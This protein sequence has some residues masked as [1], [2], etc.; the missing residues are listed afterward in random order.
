MKEIKDK[1]KIAQ[2]IV[3]PK[4][5]FKGYTI[6]EIRFQRALLAME[7]DFSKTKLLKSWNNLQR[8][9]PLSQPIGSAL[10]VKAGSIALKLVNGLN[11]M[12]YV[13][14]GWSVFNGARK[15]FSFFKKGKKK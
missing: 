10:P 8:L 6:E 5:E 1:E 2:D 15:V 11:Y 7:A 3:S 4:N 9:N 13:M 12:D 14:L